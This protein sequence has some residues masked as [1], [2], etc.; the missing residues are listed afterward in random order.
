M[1]K[2]SSERYFTE[3]SKYLIQGQPSANLGPALPIKR[4][5]KK[6]GRGLVMMGM[7]NRL[8]SDTF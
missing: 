3:Q 7:F 5:K 4:Q 8:A 2:I 1:K 6:G